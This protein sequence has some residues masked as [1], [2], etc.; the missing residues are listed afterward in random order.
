MSQY[1]TRILIRNSMLPTNFNLDAAAD[2]PSA[3]D[4]VHA[5][6]HIPNS[7]RVSTLDTLSI[8]LL[9]RAPELLIMLTSL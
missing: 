3:T 6:I 8:V 7:G 2:R 5:Y 1:S 4:Y 9:R